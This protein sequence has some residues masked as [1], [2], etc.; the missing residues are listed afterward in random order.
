M[1]FAIGSL[2]AIIAFVGIVDIILEA[3]WIVTAKHP[4]I[5]FLA[6]FLCGHL[7]W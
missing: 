5:P 2:V 3:I 4:W 7:F 6:G 1:T